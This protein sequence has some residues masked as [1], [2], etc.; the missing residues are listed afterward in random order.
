MVGNPCSDILLDKNIYWK[1]LRRQL[2][3]TGTWNSSFTGDIN[4]DWHYA[5]KKLQE[6]KI[7]P[8]DMITHR[9]PMKEMEK[10][11]HIMRDKTEDYIKIMM[12]QE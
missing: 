2:T 1:I 12:V 10:G 4:D 3:I 9:Y 8:A 5:M 7:A 11:F 6:K